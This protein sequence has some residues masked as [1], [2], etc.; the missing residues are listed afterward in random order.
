MSPTKP[1]WKL[2][3]RLHALQKRLAEQRQAAQMR[4]PQWVDTTDRYVHA[5]PWESI[6]SSAVAVAAY[7][8]TCDTVAHPSNRIPV[9]ERLAAGIRQALQRQRVQETHYEQAHSAGNRLAGGA[10]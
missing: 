1:V 10:A 6:G 3:A 7:I 2:G 9:A 4:V 8:V 5:H